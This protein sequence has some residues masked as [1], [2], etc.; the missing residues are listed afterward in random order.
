[1]AIMKLIEHNPTNWL[2]KN[3][4]TIYLTQILKYAS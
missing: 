2:S 3:P 4:N 1:M